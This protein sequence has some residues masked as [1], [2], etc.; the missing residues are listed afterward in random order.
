MSLHMDTWD[1]LPPPPIG[2][3]GMIVNGIPILDD[4]EP[5]PESL[6]IV[7]VD[8]GTGFTPVT[9]LP[10]EEAA[11]SNIRYWQRNGWKA[12]VREYIER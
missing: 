9:F 11:E 2:A 12:E 8:F 1:S 5:E 3:T 4:P 10:N 6:L 7:F